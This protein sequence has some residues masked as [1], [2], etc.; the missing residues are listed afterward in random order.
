[1][2]SLDLTPTSEVTCR[3]WLH[4]PERMGGL[5]VVLTSTADI[6]ER[7]ASGSRLASDGWGLLDIDLGVAPPTDI[8]AH[9]IGDI[10]ARALAE[11]T[12][13][14]QADLPI[15]IAGEAGTAVT[16]VEVVLQSHLQAATPAIG[17]LCLVDAFDVQPPDL[18][19]Q[20]DA[21]ATSLSELPR[22]ASIVVARRQSG[23]RRAAWDHH[24][25][26][27]ELGR[28]T[29]FLALADDGSS[30]LRRLGDALDPLGREVRWLLRPVH[31]RN[32]P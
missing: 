9:T 5:L 16:A 29:H 27:Q 11:I 6:N 25:R 17:G 23:G 31:S 18:R 7:E 15:I 19:Q 10:V 24:L 4:A 28:E 14:Q 12:S 1:M 20:F 3:A 26:L 21:L 30:L 22:L 32:P 8:V 2:L 13:A